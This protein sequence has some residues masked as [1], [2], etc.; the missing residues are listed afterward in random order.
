MLEQGPLWVARVVELG[1]CARLPA[2]MRM[3]LRWACSDGHGAVPAGG[4]RLMMLNLYPASSG[5]DVA[6]RSSHSLVN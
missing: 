2:R 4:G 6:L 3:R 1:F 5:F